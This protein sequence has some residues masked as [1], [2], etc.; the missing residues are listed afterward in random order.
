MVQALWSDYIDLIKRGA[1]IYFTFTKDLLEHILNK[2]EVEFV[3]SCEL[4]NK[5]AARYFIVEGEMAFLSDDVF[6]PGDNGFSSVI[7]LVCQQVLVVEEMVRCE[8]FSENAYF[9]RLRAF[10]S[11]DLGEISQNPFYYEDFENIWKVL[12]KEVYS[13]GNNKNCITFDFQNKKGAS[14]AKRFPLGQ[15]L[16][17]R[18]DIV[19]LIDSIGRVRVQKARPEKLIPLI[20]A[21]KKCLKKRGK[22]LITLPWVQYKL[23]EQLKVFANSNE[24]LE[25]LRK[26]VEKS[27]IN[28]SGLYSKI[29][30]DNQDWLS[31]EYVINV[32]DPNNDLV[33]DF[34]LVKHT[35]KNEIG[36]IGYRVL[37]PTLLGDSWRITDDK[38]F[39]IVGD[40]VFVLFRKDKKDTAKLIINR[41]F[42]LDEEI[43]PQEFSRVDKIGYFKVKISKTTKI[44]A[45]VSKGLFVEGPDRTEDEEEILFTGGIAVNKSQN[46]FSSNFLPDSIIINGNEHMLK[47]KITINSFV[48]TFESFREEVKSISE[49]QDYS[50]LL[51]SGIK[52]KLK[53]APRY[54]YIEKHINYELQNGKLNPTYR[55]IS[56]PNFVSDAVPMHPCEVHD[57]LQKKKEEKDF[58]SVVSILESIQSSKFS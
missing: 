54:K 43:E 45:F 25:Y 14:K 31:T 21:N 33:Q 35:L 26:E 52:F 37:T 10:M 16:F 24:N 1:P 8:N 42:E 4:I 6:V 57:L 44:N 15:A 5:L 22:Y 29:Y 40:K 3:D 7:L 2:H 20:S 46:R 36:D 53:V 39:P 11:E 55:I 30:L 27:Q 41:C 47:G 48:S 17:T 51:E 56:D 49:N 28:S 32:F 23:V 13:I 18:E 12:A 58:S 34:A 38:Y 19:R 50:I 9:P